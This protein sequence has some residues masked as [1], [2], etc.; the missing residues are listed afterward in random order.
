MILINILIYIIFI[1]TIDNTKTDSHKIL[2]EIIS[3]DK[4]HISGNIN[5]LGDSKPYFIIANPSGIDCKNCSVTNVDRL[6]LTTAK[7][8]NMLN[9]GEM[10]DKFIYDT[11]R[12]QIRF[13]NV[14]SEKFTDAAISRVFARSINLQSSQLNVNDIWLIA[15]KNRLKDVDNPK[16]INITQYKQEYNSKKFKLIIDANSIINAKDSYFH[17]NSGKLDNQGVINSSGILNISSVHSNIYNQKELIAKNQ[18]YTFIGTNFAN[19]GVI[20]SKESLAINGQN[21][22]I[23]NKNKIVANNQDYDL[24][25][26]ELINDKTIQGDDSVNITA[27]HTDIEN[28]DQLIAKNQKYRLADS[29]FKNNWEGMITTYDIDNADNANRDPAVK[30]EINIFKNSNFIDKGQ[31]PVR[32]QGND[33]PTITPINEVIHYQY[34]T[35]NI[36]K[37]GDSKMPADWAKIFTPQ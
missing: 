25:F 16:Y 24:L 36:I 14:K 31:I 8:S 30:L 34:G 29:Q 3:N 10:T 6:T 2:N 27:L 28:N 33:K 20:K 21:S 7:I 18:N 13:K 19:V 35:L 23:I 5:I 22:V 1:K 26:S 32:V 15:G 4:T 17:I 37:D 9:N 12:G 11:Q